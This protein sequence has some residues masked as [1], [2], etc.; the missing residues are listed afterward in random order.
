ML[1]E[2]FLDLEMIKE[3]LDSFNEEDIQELLPLI[4]KEIM[5]YAELIEEAE[6][7]FENP[8]KEEELILAKL[9]FLKKELINML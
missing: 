2:T 7:P 8:L 1:H 5:Y 6:I 4:E 9:Q 3:D